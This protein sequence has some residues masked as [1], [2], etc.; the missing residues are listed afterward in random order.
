M[1]NSRN[2]KGFSLIE[3]IVASIILSMAVVSICAVSTKS[4]TSVRSNRDY[5]VAWDLL[6]RQLTIIDY[7][8]IEEFINEGQMSGQFGE[9]SSSGLHYW[10]AKCE[11]GEYDYLYNLELTISWGPENAMRSISVST[12]LNGTGVVME[13]EEEPEEGG[14]QPAG[15]GGK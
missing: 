13:E 1:R 4:M 8:G 2:N 10:S 6:D 15:G 7:T 5:E 14:G 3:M 12:V 11:E 9:E